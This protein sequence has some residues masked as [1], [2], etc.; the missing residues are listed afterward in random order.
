M[1]ALLIDHIIHRKGT[2][3][4]HEAHYGPRSDAMP[5]L[6]CSRLPAAKTYA[7]DAVDLFGKV[8]NGSDHAARNALAIVDG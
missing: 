5:T 1:G 7:I 6:S 4:D 8:G 2:R 3:L